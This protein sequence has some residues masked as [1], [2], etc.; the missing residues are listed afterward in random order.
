MPTPAPN[1]IYVFATGPR[2]SIR[3]AA[4]PCSWV[5]GHRWVWPLLLLTLMPTESTAEDPFSPSWMPFS[6]HQGLHSCQSCRPQ[7]RKSINHATT[8][9]PALPC[10]HV[11]DTC[12]IR[13]RVTTHSRVL[14]FTGKGLSLQMEEAVTASSN[15]QIPQKM[16]GI[17][18]IKETWLCRRNTL[19]LR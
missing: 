15:A 18:R 6:A 8:L 12:T 11:L 5:C 3:H 4:V 2:H 1:T 14:P 19:N 10:T 16:Q 9:E 7:W 13:P 17:Q